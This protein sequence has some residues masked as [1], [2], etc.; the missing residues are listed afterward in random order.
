MD[1]IIASAAP[2]L[3]TIAGAILLGLASWGIAVLRSKCKLEAGKAALDEVDQVVKAVVGNL[4]QTT[5]KNMKAVSYT[6]L[7]LPTSDLV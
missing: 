6:H 2:Q 5:V 4:T 3:V 7:T 1:A